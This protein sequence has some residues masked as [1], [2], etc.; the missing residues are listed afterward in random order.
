M[1]LTSREVDPRDKNDVTSDY[2]KSANYV[3]LNFNLYS[4][5][6]PSSLLKSPPA[7]Q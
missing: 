6:S 3:G 1:T 7:S 4:H 2:V 5:S